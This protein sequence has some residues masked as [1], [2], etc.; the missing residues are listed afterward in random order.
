MEFGK[1]SSVDHVDFTLPRDPEDLEQRLGSA[2]PTGEAPRI[3][4]G[5]ARWQHQGFV[6]RIY[7]QGTKPKEM[8][9]AYV[10][11]FGCI[12][13]NTTFYGFDEARLAG[14]AKA[15][16]EGFLFDPKFPG[17]ITHECRLRSV[18]RELDAWLRA[19]EALDSNCGTVWALLPE[20]FGPAQGGFRVVRDFCERLPRE[21]TTMD[22]PDRRFGLEVRHADWFGPAR[23]ALVAMCQ[24][25][26][27]SLLCTDVAGRRDVC[28]SEIVTDHFALRFVGNRHHPSDFERLD[29][30]V[31]K[32][33]TWFESGLRS[34]EIFLHEPEDELVIE[35]AEH[36]GPSLEDRTGIDVLWPER[37]VVQ[38]QLGL[39]DGLDR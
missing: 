7:P 2:R 19:L 20:D 17:A 34:L 39:F 11:Q 14:W 35:L 38:K 33:G 26:G 31:E 8:L 4:L 6:E 25:L 3:R 23:S 27:I 12:E 37:V 29:R 21:F 18:E 10:T 9:A 24:E 1:L 13:L 16:P 22:A 32:I 28:H 36:L 30:W 15:A 5:A